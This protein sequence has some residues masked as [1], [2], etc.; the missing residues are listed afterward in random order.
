MVD[1]VAHYE[2]LKKEILRRLAKQQE[3]NYL[4]KGLLQKVQATVLQEREAKEAL[5]GE[6]SLHQRS[7]ELQ[8]SL[9]CYEEGFSQA[10]GGETG[11]P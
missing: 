4:Q 9:G 10:V 5:R 2:V 1:Q 3:D 6:V 11:G 8:Q 7:A